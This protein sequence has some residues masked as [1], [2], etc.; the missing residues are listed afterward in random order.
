[1]DVSHLIDPDRGLIRGDI[2]HSQ[3]IYEQEL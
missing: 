2:F 1:M 3:A